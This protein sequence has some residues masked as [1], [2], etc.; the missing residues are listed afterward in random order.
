MKL[1]ILALVTTLSLSAFAAEKPL[2]SCTVPMEGGTSNV[3]LNL[4]LTADTSADF[5]KA[6]LIDGQT[7][8]S[9]FTQL[10][11]DE[12]MTQLKAGSM[13]LFLVSET[14]RQDNGV[15][16]NGAFMGI[17]KNN[18]AFSGLL[19]AQGNLYPLQCKLAQ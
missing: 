12:A 11:K 10:K 3:S 15:L 1:S 2:L 16:R 7:T 4:T 5:V 18:E 13:G 19:S 17:A 8:T 9:F 14:S 6:T